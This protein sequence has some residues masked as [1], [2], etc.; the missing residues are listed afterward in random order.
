MIFGYTRV[1]TTEQAAD[2]T[3]SLEEQA[4][5]IRGYAMAKGVTA[6]DLQ[7]FTDAGV[8]GSIALRWRPAGQEMLEQLKPGDTVVAAKLDRIFRNSLDALKTFTAFKEQGIHLVLFDLGIEPVTGES[9]M[10]KVIFQVMS[11]FADHERERIRER[12]LDGKKAKKAKGGHTGG[13]APFGYRIVGSKRDAR[14]EIDDNEQKVIQEVLARKDKP[15]CT[16]ER[17]LKEQGFLTRDG[18]PFMHPTIRRILQRHAHA[19]H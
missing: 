2:G 14:L 18:T 17:E 19:V 10:S 4:R 13:E 6:F 1:S 3:T 9:G 16:I 12:M 8:S 15:L 5:V 7:I 11:A